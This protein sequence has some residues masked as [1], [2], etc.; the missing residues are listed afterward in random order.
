MRKI[1]LIVPVLLISNI[2][3]SQIKQRATN[4][5]GY[6]GFGY[7]FVFLTN[8]NARDAYPFFQ[9]SNGDF[10]KE[11]DGFFGV[12]INEK[13]G[14]EL[15]P[16]YLF[17]NSVSS[18]GYYFNN[19]NGNRFYVPSQTRLFAVPLELKFKYFPFAKN[20]ASSFSKF[21]FMGGGGG[22]Y[23]DEEISS[24]I[25][26][27]DSRLYLL[28]AKTFSN[29]FWTSCLEFAVGISSFS[30]IGYGFEFSYR[31]VPISNSRDI[32]VITSIASNFNSINFT[33]NIVFTF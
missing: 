18:D 12:N 16:A 22:M 19:I 4:I 5:T 8:Q 26:S 14:I 15:A 24:L 27:D 30:K 23:V 17:T 6:M 31:L 2:S 7:K 29:S 9:L 33:A 20:Y 11:I 32:P 13:Y 10:L 21:Y 3:F 28:G 25:Y 1:F